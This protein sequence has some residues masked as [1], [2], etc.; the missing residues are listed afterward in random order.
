MS[1]SQF[2]YMSIISAA[3]LLCWLRVD[4]H[5][6]THSCD[7]SLG[8]HLS[9]TVRDTLFSEDEK[10]YSVSISF[11]R[12]VKAVWMLIN[13]AIYE[14]MAI[15]YSSC[16]FCRIVFACLNIT[17]IINYRCY[18]FSSKKIIKI[19]YIEILIFLKVSVSFYAFCKFVWI[20]DISIQRST[21]WILCFSGVR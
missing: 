16:W 10:L 13:Y 12:Y 3:I 11:D 2:N 19:L 4:L 6:H 7:E 17:Q 15:I 20:T 21:N 14:M 5:S 9:G 1:D 18:I 8:F